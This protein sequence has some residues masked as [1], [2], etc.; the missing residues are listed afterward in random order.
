MLSTYTLTNGLRIVHI[1]SPTQVGY[2]GYA[3]KAGTRNEFAHQ[4][5]IA[6]LVEHML[7]KGTTHR[8]AWHILNRMENVGGDLNAYTNKEEMV[9]YAAFM[10][11]HTE[12]AIE[13]LSDI[14]FNST[15]PQHEMDKE[16]EVIIDEIQSYEDTPQELIYDDFEEIE[17]TG[18]NDEKTVAALK[19]FQ[20]YHGLPETGMLDKRTWDSA[21][22]SFNAYYGNP[23]YSS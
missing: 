12:R 16:V 3:I 17:V 22:K 19:R 2:C 4:Q 20:N 18:V 8:R 7:F 10:I 6:H 11:D 14:V 23:H 1:P 15:F 9:V 13:L 21:A 5:G